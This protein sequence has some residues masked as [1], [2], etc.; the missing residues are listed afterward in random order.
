MPDLPQ[1]PDMS[2]FYFREPGDMTPAQ[3]VF[4]AM[5]AFHPAAS[6]QAL[7]TPTD[8]QMATAILAMEPGG[9]GIE[10]L[11]R[12]GRLLDAMKSANRR[13]EIQQEIRQVRE[14]AGLPNY[15]R[16]PYEIKNPDQP[17][18]LPPSWP[19]LGY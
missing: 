12:Y 5:S 15:E 1:Q 17:L 6:G 19:K 18:M 4:D 9:P 2:P 7:P 3:R 16:G 14:E 11:R 8:E 10:T 13:R